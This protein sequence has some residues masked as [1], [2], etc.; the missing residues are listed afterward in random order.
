L[1][2]FASLGSAKIPIKSRK[3]HIFA[4][5]LNGEAKGRPIYVWRKK[6]EFLACHKLGRAF[7]GLR[8]SPVR[9]GLLE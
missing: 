4:R 1:P 5:I 9:T 6:A 8:G 2:R 7:G 3:T